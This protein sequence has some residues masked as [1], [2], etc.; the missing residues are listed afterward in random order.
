MSEL[1]TKMTSHVGRTRCFQKKNGSV[2]L[3]TNA[4]NTFKNN[5]RN[6]ERVVQVQVRRKSRKVTHYQK[7]SGKY[8]LPNTDKPLS[9][10]VERSRAPHGRPM[11]P[12]SHR[13]LGMLHNPIR[14]LLAQASHLHHQA[15]TRNAQSL[16]QKLKNRKNHKVH[17]VHKVHLRNT[18]LTIRLAHAIV[19]VKHI[20][21][22]HIRPML[23][24]ITILAHSLMAVLTVASQVK[25]YGLWSTRPNMQM[26]RV[27]TITKSRTF[28]SALHLGW[29]SLPRDLSFYACTNTCYTAR[30]RLFTPLGK[31]RLS[32]SKLTTDHVLHRG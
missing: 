10:N 30:A 25:T 31:W 27:L 2:C 21:E 16:W 19:C 14:V 28:P 15:Q 12:K 29:F 13:T 24:E 23:A 7:M 11:K 1:R 4:R 3:Q 5:A 22:S 6:A 8:Y 20:N 9:K 26:L 32:A 17:K 18:L